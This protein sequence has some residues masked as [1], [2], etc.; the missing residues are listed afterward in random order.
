MQLVSGSP[1]AAPLPAQDAQP[2][3][4]RSL[5]AGVRAGR[6]ERRVQTARYKTS[7]FRVKGGSPGASER[8]C[9]WEG[10]GAPG[11][12]LQLPRPGLPRPG[13][14]FSPERQAT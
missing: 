6:A 12:A 2:E 10:P 8:G 1:P 3:G 4:D 9:V 5:R 14:G 7:A 13:A 11:H